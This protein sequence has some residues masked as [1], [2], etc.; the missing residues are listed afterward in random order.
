MFVPQEDREDL[1]EVHVGF[2][3]TDGIQTIHHVKDLPR[4]N[5]DFIN[6]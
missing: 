6:R 2:T 5:Q 3:P 1:G 4:H